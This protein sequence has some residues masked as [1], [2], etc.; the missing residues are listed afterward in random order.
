MPSESDIP[1]IIHSATSQKSH[2]LSS[3]DLSVSEYQTYNICNFATTYDGQT[4]EKVCPTYPPISIPLAATPPPI[5]SERKYVTSKPEPEP[6]TRVWPFPNPKT[7]VYRRNPGLE[8]LLSLSVTVIVNGQRWVDCCWSR[9]V[10][11]TWKPEYAGPPHL[12]SLP[13]RANA[14]AENLGTEG[15]HTYFS[16][17]R[18][19]WSR[20]NW[21]PYDS[22]WLRWETLLSSPDKNRYFFA[23]LS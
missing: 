10:R 13:H 6:E 2:D 23:W 11:I 14:V 4:A 19:L 3:L 5:C 17:I 22:W 7:R 20:G 21:Q 9:S 8:T 18:L 16:V 12:F 1:I 15:A